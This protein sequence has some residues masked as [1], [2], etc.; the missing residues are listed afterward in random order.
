MAQVQLLKGANAHQSHID[1]K[2]RSKC[3]N[4]RPE[5]PC[6]PNLQAGQ[7]EQIQKD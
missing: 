1:A 4:T 2:K 5:Q 6:L 3:I 7:K